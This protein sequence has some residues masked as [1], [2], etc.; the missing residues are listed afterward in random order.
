MRATGNV[1]DIDCVR[2]RLSCGLYHVVGSRDLVCGQCL[3]ADL[4]YCRPH[5]DSRKSALLF[6]AA[7]GGF[8]S[9]LTCQRSGWCGLEC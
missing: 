8:M 1:S 6:S 7:H 2:A 3:L 5:V 9:R 4:D